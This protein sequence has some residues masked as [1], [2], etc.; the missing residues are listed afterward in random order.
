MDVTTLLSAESLDSQ[1]VPG[2]SLAF[3]LIFFAPLLLVAVPFFFY[4]LVA[5]ASV[6]RMAR[7]LSLLWL[8]ACIPACMLM[9]MGYAFHP[10]GLN[11]FLHIPLWI[12]AGLLPL[13]LPVGLRRLFG[14]Q[15]V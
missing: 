3:I 7:V 1:P 5:R 13:W 6:L 15:P 8:L 11:L 12:L 2:L 10:G 4:A 9:V 14:V